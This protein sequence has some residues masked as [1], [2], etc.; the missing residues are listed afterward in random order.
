[1]ISHMT[2]ALIS[3]AR[4]YDLCN[5]DIIDSELWCHSFDYTGDIIYDFVS[6]IG[7]YIICL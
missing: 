2:L 5:T 6:D 1:M 4:A 3:Y 7:Y